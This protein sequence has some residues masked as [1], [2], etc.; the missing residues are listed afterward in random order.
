MRTSRLAKLHERSVA[1]ELAINGR[2]ISLNGTAYYEK[3]SPQGAVLR[4]KV[5]DPAGDFDIVLHEDQ[6]KG[7]ITKSKNAGVDFHVHLG[8]ND[9]SIQP[10]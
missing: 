7:R 5:S 9:L 8:A 1:I 2:H 10:S 4:I 3:S 6:W